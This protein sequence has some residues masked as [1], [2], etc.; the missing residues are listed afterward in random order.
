MM[1]LYAVLSYTSYSS[2][3]VLLTF[4]ILLIFLG[5]WQTGNRARVTNRGDGE[6]QHQVTNGPECGLADF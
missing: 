1:V 5:S 6:E 4:L 2:L 3:L